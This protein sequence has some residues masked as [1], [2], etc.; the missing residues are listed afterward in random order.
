MKGKKLKKEEETKPGGREVKP[1]EGCVFSVTNQS[2]T[3]CRFQSLGSAQNKNWRSNECSFTTLN[4]LSAS[5][6][7][8]SIARGDLQQTGQ[9]QLPWA[10]GDRTTW[11]L[12]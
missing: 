10:V 2:L 12:D 9:I 3:Y 6:Q 5:C 8:P 7:G 1:F 4:T 11:L